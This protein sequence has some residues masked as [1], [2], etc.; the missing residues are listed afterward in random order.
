MASVKSVGI[1]AQNATPFL[2][3]ARNVRFFCLCNKPAWKCGFCNRARVCRSNARPRQFVGYNLVSAFRVGLAQAS[4]N[5]RKSLLKK[6][7]QAQQA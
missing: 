3:S 6:E 4:F 7:F 5:A 2:K 1:K